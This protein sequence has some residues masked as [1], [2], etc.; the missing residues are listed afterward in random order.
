DEDAKC[1]C[2]KLEK[3][4]LSL[5]LKKNRFKHWRIKTVEDFVRGVGILGG[6]P[7]RRTGGRP[8]PKNIWLGLKYLN[9]LVQGLL[10]VLEIPQVLRL[11]DV[12]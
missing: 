6:N 10:L 8:G 9:F 5:W 4:A 3:L 11:R 12:M 7:D 1:V 2:T